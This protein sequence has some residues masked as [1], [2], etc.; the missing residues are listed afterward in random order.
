MLGGGPLKLVCRIQWKSGM[1]R[2]QQEGHCD[3]LV[4]KAGTDFAA[5]VTLEVF[6]LLRGSRSLESWFVP[7]LLSPKSFAFLLKSHSSLFS[8]PSFIILPFLLK[9]SFDFFSDQLY[10]SFR[11]YSLSNQ[12][13]LGKKSQGGLTLINS[14]FF[15]RRLCSSDVEKAHTIKFGCKAFQHDFYIFC[16]WD[17]GEQIKSA[18]GC[19]MASLCLLIWNW[20]IPAVEDFVGFQGSKPTKAPG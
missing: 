3:T 5:L 14:D 12:E 11:T 8:H 19:P 1:V 18:R 6:R 16:S 2:C 10:V 20:C 17:F 15:N 13:W 4:P 9:T 7:S